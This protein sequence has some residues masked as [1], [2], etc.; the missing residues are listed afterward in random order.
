V[1]AW[2]LLMNS[3]LSLH[4]SC[5]LMQPL[6]GARAVRHMEAAQEHL[7]AYKS[8]R[9]RSTHDGCSEHDGRTLN[10]H[11]TP[12]P[13]RAPHHCVSS[14]QVMG[15]VPQDDVMLADM[16]VEEL[17]HFSARMRLPAAARPADH[18]RH[19]DRT[20]KVC[21]CDALSRSVQK[22]CLVRWHR[23][24][25]VEGEQGSACWHQVWVCQWTW[26]W[27]RDNDNTMVRTCIDHGICQ[28]PAPGLPRNLQQQRA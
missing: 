15:Y 9:P 22:V 6:C 24:E 11:T 12:V 23:A 7:A 21:H 3:C 17:L 1:Y 19:V 26:V 16:T 14:S 28:A 25:V 18:L 5:M 20:I 8:R 4:L 2:L 27:V 13:R 10:K